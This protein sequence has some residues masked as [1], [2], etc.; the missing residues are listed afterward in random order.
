MSNFHA[1]IIQGLVQPWNLEQISGIG[2]GPCFEANPFW[3]E[4]VLV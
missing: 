1:S 4:Y 2:A 3:A